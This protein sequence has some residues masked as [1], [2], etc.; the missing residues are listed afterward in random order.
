MFNDPIT[1]DK[2]ETPTSLVQVRRRYGRVL[3]WLKSTVDRWI[4]SQIDASPRSSS[5]SRSRRSKSHAS[6]A[7]DA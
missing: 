5:S 7:A 6:V 2:T 3:I 1:Y 4:M